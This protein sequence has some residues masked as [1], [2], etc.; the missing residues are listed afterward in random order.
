MAYMKMPEFLGLIKLCKIFLPCF[1]YTIP[2]FGQVNDT[3]KRETHI[4][5]SADDNK[6]EFST[7][8]PPLRQIQGAPAAF[9][10]Y[11]WEFGDGL[12]SFNPKPKHHYME[13]GEFK[14]Q[15][16]T[17]NNY[18]NGKPPPSR[19]QKVQVNKITYEDNNEHQKKLEENNGFLLQHNHS[20]VPDEEMVVILSYANHSE[21]V[22]NGK[23][24]FFYNEEQFQ[25]DNFLISE[26]RTHHGEKE[27]EEQATVA[28]HFSLPPPNNMLAS[29]HPSRGLMTT[30]VSSLHVQEKSLSTVLE[31]S[32]SHF[33]NSHVLEFNDMPSM[34]ERNIF[35]SLRITS[36]MIKDTS[37]IVK[38]R[39]VYVPDGRKGDYKVK[40]LEMEIVKS[41]D[42]NKMSVSDT[43]I[44]YRFVESKEIQFKIRFQNNGEGPAKSIKLNVD[45]PDAYNKASLRIV[46]MY[47]PCPICP[48]EEVH[49]SCLDTLMAKGKI[50]FHFKNIY[51]PGSN[52]ENVDEK[53]STKGFVKYAL[54]F[55][56][57]TPKK[58]TASRTA[59]VFDK[60]DPILT[61]Y[62]ATRFV[63][64]ISYGAKAGYNY[65]PELAASK[66]FFVGITVS[67]YK[68]YRSY[69]QTEA[70]LHYHSYSDISTFETSSA[71]PGSLNYFDLY[72]VNQSKNYS[73]VG[74]NVVPLSYR[75]NISKTIGWGTGVQVSGDFYRK[76]EVNVHGQYYLL[77][78]DSNNLEYRD[79][80]SNRDYSSYDVKKNNFGQ[81]NT[82]IFVEIVA[83]S[84]RIGP[85]FAVRYV[86]NV[87]TP[88]QQWQLSALWKF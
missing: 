25:N 55:N 18:D 66:S 14:A 1:L 74:F 79:R 57:D 32:K 15:V 5:F 37:A 39:G 62:A 40:D 46:D 64:G 47:P 85:S 44:N 65:F 11:Y 53:D 20:P 88:R 58:R 33:R 70:M 68:S 86:H 24:Y 2:A 51:L 54:H 34:E 29:A 82:G 41:H 50:I 87:D 83:G 38:V 6:V 56:K 43:R 76:T 28:Q 36:E 23:I 63:P 80:N 49:F 31:E 78:I 9:Y 67:P 26:V 81:M 75:Y 17:T 10:S 35:Y 61:N 7:V 42:P 77:Y 3:I 19:P 30:L 22:A 48:T 59:I 73:S 45:V 72:E 21:N 27:I 84:S 60:N 8:A 4:R 16:W 69:W 13:K 71:V 52:Q 12:Y